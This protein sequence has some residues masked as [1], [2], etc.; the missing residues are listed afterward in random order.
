MV[1][2]T[3]SASHSMPNPAI[4]PLLPL[5]CDVMKLASCPGHLPNCSTNCVLTRGTRRPLYPGFTHECR[6]PVSIITSSPQLAGLSDT[7]SE[8][9]FTFNA[10]TRRVSD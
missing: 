5:L 7:E 6:T 9:R 8:R 3:V 1:C 10:P 2:A 4:K